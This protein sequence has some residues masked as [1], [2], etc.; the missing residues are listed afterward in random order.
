MSQ[1][2][3][4]ILDFYRQGY[5]LKDISFVYGFSIYMLKKF[6]ANEPKLQ[7]LGYVWRSLYPNIN[8]YPEAEF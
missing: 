7:P 4:E 6:L 1:D 5:D 8:G 2:E 3:T